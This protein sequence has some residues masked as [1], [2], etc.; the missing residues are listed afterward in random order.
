MGACRAVIISLEL[1]GEFFFLS[2]AC[3]TFV[4]FLSFA[5][6]AVGS[7]EAKPS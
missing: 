6:H 3:G 5:T 2:A 4:E 1:A 7:P